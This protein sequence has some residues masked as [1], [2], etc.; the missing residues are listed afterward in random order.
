MSLINGATKIEK[1][2]AA[3]DLKAKALKS[4]AMAA[5][6]IGCKY[7]RKPDWNPV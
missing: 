5:G 7:I 1:K 4:A 6:E 3:I 2:D